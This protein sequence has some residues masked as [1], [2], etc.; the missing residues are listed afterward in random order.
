[1]GEMVL[2]YDEYIEKGRFNRDLTK[3][4]LIS[5][6]IMNFSDVVIK[7]SEDNFDVSLPFKLKVDFSYIS[8]TP[9]LGIIDSREF[10]KSSVIGIDFNP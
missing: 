8:H 1:M 9:L 3:E 2:S 5:K 10:D 7:Y 6:F 4:V